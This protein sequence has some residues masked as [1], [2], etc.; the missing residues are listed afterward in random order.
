MTCQWFTWIWCVYNQ[1][2]SE[3]N[4]SESQMP[5]R[6]DLLCK[7]TLILLCVHCSVPY[8]VSPQFLSAFFFLL[9]LCCFALTRFNGKHFCGWISCLLLRLVC[10][11]FISLCFILHSC[12]PSLCPDLPTEMAG[13][14][15][16]FKE[17]AF[18]SSAS[19]TST[20]GHSLQHHDD[21]T[22]KSPLPAQ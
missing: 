4:F 16:K 18:L 9:P 12:I 6:P 13:P 17:W 15:R 19:L 2:W 1:K 10:S 22:H 5:Q 14:L 8:I 3:R 7:S 21:Y 20:L 11:V